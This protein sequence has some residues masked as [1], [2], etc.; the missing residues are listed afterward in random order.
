MSSMSQA[1]H[2]QVERM[3]KSAR[4]IAMAFATAIAVSAFA[5]LY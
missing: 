3:L 5:Y 4:L 1:D 2:E